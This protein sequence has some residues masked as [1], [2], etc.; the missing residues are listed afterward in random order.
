M[1]SQQS[2]PRLVRLRP[3]RRS[4]PA[5]PPPDPLLSSHRP[6][7]L[8]A[9]WKGSWL[10][11]PFLRKRSRSHLTVSQSSPCRAGTMAF[12][13]SPFPTSTPSSPA[14]KSGRTHAALRRHL[15]CN[16]VRISDG[17]V[18]P[19]PSLHTDHDS[20]PLFVQQLSCR[21]FLFAAANKT[22]LTLSQRK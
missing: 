11:T 15:P 7:P 10:A 22:K 13:V 8:A 2:L 17:L 6:P 1:T 21:S 12:A 3:A 9:E 4:A 16:V 20:L 19:R 18:C 14:G 5:L